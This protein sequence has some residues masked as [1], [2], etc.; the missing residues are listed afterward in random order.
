M[1][2][3][4]KRIYEPLSPDDGYRV[5][6]DRL[7]PRGIKKETANFDEWLKDVAPSTALRKWFNHEPEKWEAFIKRYATELKDSVAFKE[8]KSL[9]ARHKHV[10]LLYSAKDH[11]H[12]Q[13]VALHKLL[14]PD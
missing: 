11:E 14:K 13:A 9:V 1:P 4:I 8:L 12:N 10:T 2:V 5:L 6:V 3:H 7:W